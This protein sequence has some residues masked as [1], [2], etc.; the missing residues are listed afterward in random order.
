MMPAID[1][2]YDARKKRVRVAQVIT[3]GAIV[4]SSVLDGTRFSGWEWVPWVLGLTLIIIFTAIS[5]NSAGG[6]RGRRGINGLGA[7]GRAC[8][9]PA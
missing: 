7:H 8:G 6:P 9:R 5:M 3:T 4:A 2:R 1:P